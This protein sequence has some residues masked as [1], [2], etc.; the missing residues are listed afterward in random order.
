MP[1]RVVDRVSDSC[2]GLCNPSPVCRTSRTRVEE[3]YFA[4]LLFRD[5]LYA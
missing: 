1:K 2:V 3:I 5:V 4:M